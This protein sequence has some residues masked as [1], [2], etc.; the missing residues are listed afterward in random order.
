MLENKRTT[1]AIRDRRGRQNLSLRDNRR[2]GAFP[3]SRSM[4]I[5]IIFVCLVSLTATAHGPIPPE[6]EEFGK[7]TWLDP[8]L[9][10]LC[11][12]NTTRLC[13]EFRDFEVGSPFT[14]SFCCVDAIDLADGRFSDC[15]FLFARPPRSDD[16]EEEGAGGQG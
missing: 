11:G 6:S 12:N 8:T 14:G 9:T 15:L 13:A 4:Y 1:P 16:D 3:L 5:L 7:G 10:P 2:R